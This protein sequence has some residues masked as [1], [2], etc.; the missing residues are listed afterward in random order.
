MIA[1]FWVK[2][3]VDDLFMKR[4]T[5]SMRVAFVLRSAEVHLLFWDLCV[6]QLACEQSFTSILTPLLHLSFSR[7]CAH[8]TWELC[9]SLS[10]LP[11][12]E[13]FIYCD[14]LW[15]FMELC[16]TLRHFVALCGTLWHFVALC[17]TLWHS[18]ALCGTLWHSVALCG[19][20]WHFVITWPK[21]WASWCPSFF[22]QIL[23]P[24]F[25]L[26][27]TTTTNQPNTSHHITQHPT[28]T[29]N[30]HH[31]NQSAKHITQ[32]PISLTHYTTTNQ[33]P[34]SHQAATNQSHTSHNKQSAT[35][36][37]P[38]SHISQ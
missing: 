30:Q 22:L 7:A 15:L 25:I 33:P 21:S 3:F 11:S 28:T 1:V 14:T 10:N 27:N 29:Q 38:T 6:N 24:G 32:Q 9:A 34:S 31:C 36:Q 37:P 35:N 26:T 19:T 2:S 8:P 12:P 5:V 17:G 23:Y 13:V 4:G 20:L 16:G 18:V